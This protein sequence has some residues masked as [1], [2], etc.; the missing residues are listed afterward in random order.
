MLLRT[1]GFMAMMTDQAM[2]LLDSD[3]GRW[4]LLR[5]VQAASRS[6][7]RCGAKAVPVMPM[8]RA[9]LNRYRSDKAFLDHC[10]RLFRLPCVVAGV[11]LQ[12]TEDR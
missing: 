4:P 10:R 9:A 12:D 11:L 8:L 3:C 1:R 2:R 6:C 7:G 5:A